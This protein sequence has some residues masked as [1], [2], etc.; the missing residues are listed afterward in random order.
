MRSAGGRT[1][2][3]AVVTAYNRKEVKEIPVEWEE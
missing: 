2:V 3:K 1:H